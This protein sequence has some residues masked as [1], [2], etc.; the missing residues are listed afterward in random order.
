MSFII[1]DEWATGDSF[2]VFLSGVKIYEYITPQQFPGTTDTCGDA[3]KKDFSSSLS[4][5]AKLPSTSSVELKIVTSTT[6]TNS[7]LAY[8]DITLKGESTPIGLIIGTVIAGLVLLITIALVVRCI[9]KKRKE[10][11]KLKY[12]S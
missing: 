11:K 6:S 9:I 5:K 4:G 8:N 7:V 1:V 3:N 10:I 12:E 2:S